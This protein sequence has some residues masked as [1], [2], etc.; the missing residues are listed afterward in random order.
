MATKKNL[1]IQILI[2]AKD[3]ASATL[4]KISTAIAKVGVAISA[5]ASAAAAWVGGQFFAESV[6]EAEALERQ[7]VRLKAVIE[8][9]GGAA[10]LTADEVNAM[11][12]RL[13]EL[14]LGADD[15]FRDA[16]AQLLTFKA[17][18]KD[19]FETVLELAQDLAD[20]GFGGLEENVTRLGK[21]LE[22]P[23]KGL[24]ALVRVGVSFTEQQ[25]QMVAAMQQAGN[26]AGA[27]AI[28]L[29]AVAGQ[30]GGVAR[31]MGD[32]L[33]GAAD[34]VAQ[35]FG[36]LKE[37]L[38]GAILP[39]LADFNR[40]LADVYAR[41]SDSGAV[42]RLGEVFAE[43]ARQATEAM[44]RFIEGVDLEGLA[45][46]IGAFAS[47][48]AERMQ[49]WGRDLQL[50]VEGSSRVIA[51]ANAA[52]LVF[53]QTVE[54]SAAGIAGALSLLA[55]AW[56]T[57]VEGAAKV[58][59]ATEESA[60]KARAAQE[61]L[62][63]A[64][65][66]YKD[67]SIRHWQEAGAAASRAFLGVQ[68][69]A[70]A[71]TEVAQAAAAEIGLTA[72]EL[73][74]LGESAAYAAAGQAALAPATE[75]VAVAAGRAASATNA[76]VAATLSLADA[77]SREL[78]LADQAL[79]V[80]QQE[81]ALN[82]QRLSNLQREAEARG[83]VVRAQQ[84][85]IQVARAEAAG[86]EAVAR[87]TQARAEAALAAAE[88]LRAKATATGDDTTETLAALEAAELHAQALGLESQAAA[89]AARSAQ[90][91][92]AARRGVA[93]GAEDL[94]AGEEQAA[95]TTIVLNEQTQLTGD[96]MRW[97]VGEINA[98]TG[99]LA[100]YSQRAKETA[101]AII[102]GF[103][104]FEDKTRAIRNLDE[105]ALI[106]TDR[107]G[108]L[109]NEL[110][111]LEQGAAEA[112]D[113]IQRLQEYIR[114]PI[115][116]DWRGFY[117]GL[118]DIAELEKRLALAAATQKRMEIGAEQLGNRL[119]ALQGDYQ[120][121]ALSIGEYAQ[122]L[123]GL[124]REFHF[125]GEEQLE[126]LRAA[127]TDAQRRLEDLRASAAD[128]LASL[129][130][131]LDQLEDRQE[132]VE[133]RSYQRRQEEL[134]QR[135]E[136]ARQSSNTQAVQDLQESLAVLDRIHAKR[137]ADLEA[138]RRKQAELNAERAAPAAAPRAVPPANVV[139]L[140]ARTGA[141]AGAAV[142][143]NI[144]GVLDV[145]DRATLETLARKLRPVFEDLGRR[146]A[147]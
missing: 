133:Q 89:E 21:A 95:Q 41:L 25:R 114:Q 34:L 136:E 121:G 129:R 56:A 14:T 104:A 32:G 134:A 29:E 132:S 108:T 10:G 147:A 83:Q 15:Q 140:P 67:A 42:T 82:V 118:R 9:T 51:A 46:R 71:A 30:V 66:A 138:E 126:P 145:N 24:T 98:A 12:E 45:E 113:V 74:R 143:I 86:A 111:Q 96:L 48:T 11:A 124:Q 65:L 97:M 77:T 69:S 58:G 50:A 92:A 40:R 18:G 87:A 73:D 137:M 101:D 68:E 2:D 107:L 90:A 3:A 63:E 60:L 52:W 103:G 43:M 131:E 37:Q 105:Y 75:S 99:A 116:L 57:A 19:V 85:A 122:Q 61:T 22:D 64:A 146:G 27:Q 72:D 128:T 6:S 109:R 8:A 79:R 33:S 117:E 123:N 125:L 93:S 144:E 76:E 28:I 5:A 142:T 39:A 110:A 53:R 62:A 139:P 26:A 91:L 127:I 88:A 17:V 135:L 54:L 59:L 112:G 100:T 106:A 20:S 44:G 84:L 7:M 55:G 16:A 130:D 120:S 4:G 78:K 1:A 81:A 35:R 94:A 102:A 13:G 38:G 23:A 49:A 70:Q 80:A 36:D 141:A 47:S 115:L 119:K 31:A